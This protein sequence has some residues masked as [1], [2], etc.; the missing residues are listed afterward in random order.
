M[1]VKKIMDKFHWNQ[2][3]QTQRRFLLKHKLMHTN[4]HIFKRV[5]SYYTVTYDSA[6]EQVHH[7]FVSVCVSSNGLKAESQR[8]SIPSM[9]Y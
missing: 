9:P 5:C 7:L 4:E 3:F 6:N 1:F 2:T 8:H